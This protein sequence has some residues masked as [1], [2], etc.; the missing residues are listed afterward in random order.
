MRCNGTPD[1]TILPEINTFM[2]LWHDE[3]ERLDVDDT[4]QQ[5]NLVLALIKELTYVIDSIP[6][7]SPELER[8]P[9]YK[10]VFLFYQQ[11]KVYAIAYL[12]SSDN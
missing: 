1:P 5:T 6:N 12:L 9:I 11:E 3:K 8:V 10:K 2:S 7:S 4:M